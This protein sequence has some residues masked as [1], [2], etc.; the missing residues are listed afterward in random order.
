[1]MGQRALGIAVPHRGYAELPWAYHYRTARPGL[2]GIAVDGTLSRCSP[3][4]MR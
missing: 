4:T 1:V 2:A 3:P